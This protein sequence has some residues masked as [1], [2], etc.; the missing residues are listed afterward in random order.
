MSYV[1]L[2][3]LYCKMSVISVA[4]FVGFDTFYQKI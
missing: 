1:F 2:A 3:K 4:S